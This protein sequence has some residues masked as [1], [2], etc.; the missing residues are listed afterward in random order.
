MNVFY[1][2]PDSSF[3]LSMM[4]DRFRE[5]FRQNADWLSFTF[6]ARSEFPD[7]PYRNASYE[8]LRHDCQQVVREIIRFA[9]PEVLRDSTTLHFG[10]CTI[11]GVRALRDE[12]YRSLCGY[13]AVNRRGETLV[14]YH[15]TPEQARRAQTREGFWDEETGLLIT[16]LDLVLNALELT[17]DRV[18]PFLDQLSERPHESGLIQMVIHEQYFYSDYPVYEP[19]YAQRILAMARWLAGHGYHSVSHSDLMA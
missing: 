14:A 13:L 19:D 18:E 17:A 8:E 12:G 10:A 9:G 15:L 2:S 4:T 1:A 7:A 11:E 5:Q 16:R 3:N 6:H